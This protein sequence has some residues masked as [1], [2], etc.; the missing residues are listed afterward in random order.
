MGR[1]IFCAWIENLVESRIEDAF[2]KW[3]AQGLEGEVA[4]QRQLSEELGQRLQEDALRRVEEV[5]ESRV[6]GPHSHE[7][8]DTRME[9]QAASVGCALEAKLDTYRGEAAS[10][11]RDLEAKLDKWIE[12]VAE[13]LQEARQLQDALAAT[14]RGASDRLSEVIRLSGLQLGSPQALLPEVHSCG[15]CGTMA[16][17]DLGL[18]LDR[19]C[20]DLAAIIGTELEAALLRQQ[21]GLVAAATAAI[22]PGLQADLDTIG[23]DVARLLHEAALH[24]RGPE[25]ITSTVEAIRPQL[26]E[27]AACV[28][29]A[30][31]E[32]RAELDR[33]RKEASAR[34]AELSEALSLQQHLAG[35]QRRI[36]E[37]LAPACLEARRQ[38]AALTEAVQLF[39][40]LREDLD[41]RIG[42]LEAQ[43][44]HVAEKQATDCLAVQAFVEEAADK[45]A[46]EACALGSRLEER[47]ESLEGGWGTGAREQAGEL[48]AVRRRTQELHE[49]TVEEL[50][51]CQRQN[52]RLKEQLSY[53]EAFA[54]ESAER[55]V[56]LVKEV[57]DRVAQLARDAETRTR[58]ST[59]LERRLV[60]LENGPAGAL[61]RETAAAL[62]KDVHDKI[63]DI[64]AHLA[65][66]AD[67]RTRQ[68][69][70]VEHRFQALEQGQDKL[71][72]Q[73]RVEDQ[74]RWDGRGSEADADARE[75]GERRLGM[76]EWRLSQ[77][78]QQLQQQQQQRMQQQ[79]Q[80]PLL[81]FEIAGASGVTRASGSALVASV[82]TIPCGAGGAVVE[83]WRL[84]LHEL[85]RDTVRGPS[86]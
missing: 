36:D 56:T 28:Q 68:T 77:A 40:T 37:E 57:Q 49:Y 16:P 69:A 67:A 19:C 44:G 79:Q 11:G 84:L 4:R 23:R 42:V 52:N 65:A 1:G 31:L 22:R 50:T 5:A 26:E 14:Q 78:E 73:M 18:G 76:L 47:I 66:D 72:L 54:Q 21:P 20:E 81:Q 64:S 83:D 27:L 34:Q 43:L 63:L 30:Q 45:Q 8:V 55:H 6:A 60:A 13:Q 32:L 51:A 61:G 9:Q 25:L 2:D 82:A 70:V 53:L 24:V 75:R 10:M 71:S 17:G 74:E 38:A 7:W 33:V 48:Q 29:D 3:S 35:K 62:V 12:E 85:K 58:Q 46:T 39:T 80:Q 41:Q 15:G 59:S 86:R